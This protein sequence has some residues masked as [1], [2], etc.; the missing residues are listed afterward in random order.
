MTWHPVIGDPQQVFLEVGLGP[1][2]GVGVVGKGIYKRAT[3]RQ[4]IKLTVL[5]YSALGVM[6]RDESGAFRRVRWYRVVSYE[7]RASQQLA[8]EEERR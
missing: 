1:G 4:V 6:G 8:P 5:R 2:D 7:K 3:E